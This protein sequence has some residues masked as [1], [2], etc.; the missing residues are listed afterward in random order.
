MSPL[1]HIRNIPRQTADRPFS[2]PIDAR[3]HHGYFLNEDGAADA[4]IARRPQG[5]SL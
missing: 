3:R 1:P 2:L 4:S 5:K